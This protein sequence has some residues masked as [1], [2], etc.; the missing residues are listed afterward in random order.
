MQYGERARPEPLGDGFLRGLPV[1]HAPR[2][3]SLLLLD[4]A[5]APHPPTSGRRAAARTRDGRSTGSP[6]HHVQYERVDRRSAAARRSLRECVELTRP[7]AL[8]IHIFRPA[9]SPAM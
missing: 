4:Q 6:S 8:V 3:A 9:R 7:I 5:P 1:A 2:T